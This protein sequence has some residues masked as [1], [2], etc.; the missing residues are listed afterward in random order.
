MPD[1][2]SD[3]CPFLGAQLMPSFYQILDSQC[4]VM[5]SNGYIQHPEVVGMLAEDYD[6]L[7]E[8]PLDCIVERILPRQCRSLSLD[9]PVKLAVSLAKSML[10]SNH[11]GTV[12]GSLTAKNG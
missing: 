11:E 1:T 7:I 12:M 10:A 5:G 3:I 2:L 6:Y 9:D 4:F 8:K